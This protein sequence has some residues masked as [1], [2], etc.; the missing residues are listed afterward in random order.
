MHHPSLGTHAAAAQAAAAAAAAA[1]PGASRA[2]APPAATAT[3]AAAIIATACAAASL[4]AAA[5]ARSRP[6]PA[7]EGAAPSTLFAAIASIADAAAAAPAAATSP[8]PVA[9]TGG[10]SR[11]APTARPELD[12]F[13]VAYK[14]RAGRRDAARAC[15]FARSPPALARPDG[16]CRGCKLRVGRSRVC[17][18]GG[19]ASPPGQRAS[20]AGD[21]ERER[22]RGAGGG[23]SRARGGGGGGSC[24]DGRRRRRCGRSEAVSN[25]ER[26]EDLGYPNSGPVCGERTF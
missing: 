22:H 13:W 19:S 5:P 24:G 25:T 14:R 17:S 11:P 6:F 3:A 9:L 15:R 26:R 23:R 18:G 4:A 8:T 1:A 16:S 7:A 10:V 2:I 12:A 20:D 21:A